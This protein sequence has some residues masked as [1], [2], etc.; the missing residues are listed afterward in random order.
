MGMGG[1]CT[2][3]PLL[4]LLQTWQSSLTCKTERGERSWTSFA[5]QQTTGVLAPPKAR[6]PEDKRKGGTPLVM[7]T[8]TQNYKWGQGE[9]TSLASIHPHA[10]HLGPET[11]QRKRFKLKIIIMLDRDKC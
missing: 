5:L 6:Q 8:V 10:F 7:V 2:F 11:H 9:R 1:G 3:S 4:K